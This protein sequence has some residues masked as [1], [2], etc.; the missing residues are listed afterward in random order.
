MV[1]LRKIEENKHETEEHSYYST[2]RWTI[3]IMII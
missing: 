3:E 2:E 1:E